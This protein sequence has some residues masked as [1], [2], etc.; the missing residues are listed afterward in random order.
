MGLE[1]GE[2]LLS[3]S[4]WITAYRDSILYNFAFS[5]IYFIAAGVALWKDTSKAYSKTAIRAVQEII[6]EN[7]YFVLRKELKKIIY[8]K[9]CPIFIIIENAEDLLADEIEIIKETLDLNE[10]YK[11]TLMTHSS[12]A[13]DTRFKFANLFAPSCYAIRMDAQ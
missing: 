7:N 1:Q 10:S 12:L 5:C 6:N 9:N 3:S 11:I 8:D 4:A 2:N 13:G